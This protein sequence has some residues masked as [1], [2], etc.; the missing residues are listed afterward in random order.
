MAE[1]IYE[2]NLNLMRQ[3]FSFDPASIP[4][5]LIANGAFFSGPSC[6]KQKCTEDYNLDN[7]NTPQS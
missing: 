4:D 2:A 6:S 5:L 3:S 7:S 1:T